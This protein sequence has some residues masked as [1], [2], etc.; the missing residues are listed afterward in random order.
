MIT[1]AQVAAL[2]PRAAPDH[3]V[4]MAGR[5]PAL[6]A[7]L[8]ITGRRLHFLLAQVGHESAGLTRVEEGLNYSAARLVAV[9]PKRYPDIAAAAPFAN[10][11]QKLANTLYGGRLGNGPPASGDG[12]RFR[13]RGYIQI[14]GR[15]NYGK[16]GAI[17]GVDIIADPGAAASADHALEIAC[18]YWMSRNLNA[19]ADT[20]DYEAVTRAINGKMIGIE[21]RRAWLDKVTRIMALPLAAKVPEPSAADVVAVQRALQKRGFSG[22]GAADGDPG[23]RTMAAVTEFRRRN[24][25]PVGGIDAALLQM[26][27]IAG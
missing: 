24:A 20:N 7:R 1:A 12:Y 8:A 17:A 11:P 19:I 16:I 3:Q 13:G 14:T 27:G 15:E 9:F 5:G 21:D 2:F 26:L 22:V 23:P 4:A 10:N 18:G 6:F 25:M